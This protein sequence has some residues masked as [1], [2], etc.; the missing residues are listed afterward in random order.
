MS[1]K[2]SVISLKMNWIKTHVI[3]FDTDSRCKRFI[4]SNKTNFTLEANVFEC[5]KKFRSGPLSRWQSNTKIIIQHL[6]RINFQDKVSIFLYWMA[7]HEVHLLG[8]LKSQVYRK[9]PHR[10]CRPQANIMRTNQQ[11]SH[12]S[13]FLMFTL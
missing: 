11:K 1:I 3:W 5:H 7:V 8:Y 6:W 12:H 4:T 2:Y 9:Q 10:N 13:L